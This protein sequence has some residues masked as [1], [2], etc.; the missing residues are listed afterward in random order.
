MHDPGRE[1][2]PGPPTIE[3]NMAAE[4][5]ILS[6]ARKGEKIVLDGT[7]FRAGADTRCDV[8]FDPRSDPPAKNRS[9]ALWLTS[10]GWV[11]RSPGVGEVL[12][13]PEPLFGGPQ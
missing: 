13:H 3:D 11:I 6:G 2:R 10:D 9:V 4:I 7:E 8:Y 1:K 5:R 12:P